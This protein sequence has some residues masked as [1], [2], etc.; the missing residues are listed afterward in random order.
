M[1]VQFEVFQVVD[2]PVEKVFAFVAR[3]HVRNHPRWDTDIELEQM[4]EGPIGVG[5]MIRRRNKRSGTP[6][7]GTME[8]V[9]FE[10]D[11][12]FATIIREGP[13][14]MY[15]RITFEAVGEAQTRV[16]IFFEMP[17]D[18]SRVDRAFLTSRLEHSGRIRKELIES[19]T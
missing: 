18:E 13:M 4:S 9:E 16:T 17:V 3:E 11:R 7:E 15:G 6:V 2:R 5:T 19:E 14:Q 10:P 12:A 8:V 1:P